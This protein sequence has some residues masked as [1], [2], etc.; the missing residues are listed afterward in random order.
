MTGRRFR[1]VADDYGLS[2]GVSEGIRQLLDRGRL[3][4]TGCM[5]LFPE[6]AES[7]RA[8]R[9]LSP[10]AE[11]GLHLTL[12]D[13]GGLSGWGHLPHLKELITGV[14]RGA[15]TADK[16]FPELD[17]QLDRF[18]A[19]FGR[20]PAYL[21]GHQHVHFL[22]PVRQW[23]IARFA[24][25]PDAEKPWVRGGPTRKGAPA[26][27]WPKILFIRG[28]AT[29]F[30]RQMR[31]AGL[32]VKGPLAGFYAWQKPG[33]FAEAMTT[34]VRSL[35]DGAVVMCHPGLVDDVLRARDVLTDSRAEE[36]EFLAGDRFAALLDRAGATLAGRAA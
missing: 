8:M 14:S 4:G 16:V 28:L 25:L 9:D 33:L 19:E 31:A 27:L 2:P 30:D 7:A 24:H 3:S 5:T 29:G 15:I 23:I 10:N 26:G 11:M 20:L 1:L 34:L 13:F 12:T 22:A 18:T 36:L 32:P 17:A 35:P 21:D 6:W